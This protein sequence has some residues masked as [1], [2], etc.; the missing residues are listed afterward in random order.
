M[1]IWGLGGTFQEQTKE[2]EYDGKWESKV[3]SIGEQSP[4]KASG[5]EKSGQTTV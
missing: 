5:Q 4:V 3:V 1:G 2:Q